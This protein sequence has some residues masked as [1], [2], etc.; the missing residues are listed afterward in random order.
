[1]LRKAAQLYNNC[2]ID[3]GSTPDRIRKVVRQKEEREKEQEGG[4]K[5][6]IRREAYNCT[7]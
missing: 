4:R 5:G 6:E 7:K 3:M 2:Q 1:M